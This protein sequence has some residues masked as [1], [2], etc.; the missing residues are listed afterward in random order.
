MLIK[1]VFKI[2][3]SSLDFNNPEGIK[4]CLE[5][6]CNLIEVLYK[7]NM[8]LK[9]ENQK[10]KDEINK[11]KGERGK[12]DIKA[13]SS[14]KGSK[15]EK[16]LSKATK[17][18]KKWQKGSKLDKIKID[19]IRRIRRTGDHANGADSGTGRHE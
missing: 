8:E 16:S 14:K 10:L 5:H 9:T 15:E 1:D 7:E 6:L 13:N 11:L 19:T 18:K 2:D 4:V 17:Q 3:P 12:P